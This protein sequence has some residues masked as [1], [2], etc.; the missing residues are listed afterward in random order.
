[1]KEMYFYLDCLPFYF[2]GYSYGGCWNGWSCPLFDKDTTIQILKEMK[3]HNFDI[4]YFIVNDTIIIKQYDDEEIFKPNNSGFYGLGAYS[5][6]W[7]EISENDLKE[8]IWNS[9]KDDIVKWGD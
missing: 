6:T 1:M 8:Q 2:K 4:D 9:Y 7:D 5:W 3:K